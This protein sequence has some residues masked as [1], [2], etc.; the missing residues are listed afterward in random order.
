MTELGFWRR[1]NRTFGFERIGISVIRRQMKAQHNITDEI[2]EKYLYGKEDE[3]LPKKTFEWKP[4][5]EKK[6]GRSKNTWL[7]GI[8]ADTK[9]KLFQRTCREIER[10]DA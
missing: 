10:S 9:Q 8:L 7:F 4:S 5:G 6:K 3:T 1:E 2:E